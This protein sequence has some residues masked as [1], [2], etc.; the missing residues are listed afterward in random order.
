MAIPRTRR[1]RPAPPGRLGR[2]HPAP[3]SRAASRSRPATT[4]SQR[5]RPTVVRPPDR[6]GAPRRHGR[7]PGRQSSGPR[8]STSVRQQQRSG[9]TPAARRQS[10]P[11]GAHRR[12]PTRGRRLVR[13][14]SRRPEAEASPGRQRARRDPRHPL[15]RSGTTAPR[16]LVP[17]VRPARLLDVP[18]APPRARADLVAAARQWPRGMVPGSSDKAAP[19]LPIRAALTA[20]SKGDHPRGV[21]RNPCRNRGESAVPRRNEPRSRINGSL[22]DRSPDP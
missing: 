12:P 20:T 9:R 6:H 13:A 14:P 5:P 11:Q 21:G 2:G 22:R 19:P 16:P 10:T 17:D 8:P 3:R 7:R 1:G 18:A 15:R 4:P